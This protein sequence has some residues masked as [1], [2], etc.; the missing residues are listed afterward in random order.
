MPE[1]SGGGARV[2]EPAPDFELSSTLGRPTTRRTERLADGGRWRVL[3]FYPRDF[4]FVCPTELIELSARFEDFRDRECSLL[5]ISADDLETHERWIVTPEKDGG[6]GPLR[7]PLA[8]D[9]D[10]AVAR[11]YGVWVEDKRVA[12]R[13]LFVVD[14]GGVLQYA[15]VHNLGVGRNSAEVLRVIDALRGGGLCPAGWRRGDGTI[16]PGKLLHEGRVLGRYR[17]RGTLGKG[18]FG[19]VLSAWDLWLERDV[20]LKVGAPGGRAD[21]ARVLAEARSAA[22]LNHPNICTVYAVEE[23]EGLPVIAMEHLSGRPLSRVLAGG[24]LPEEEARRIARGIA[25][26]LAASHAA[27]VVHG[28]LKPANVMITDE[29]RVV[30]LDFGIA[31]RHGRIPRPEARLISGGV[32]ISSPDAVGA[33]V[34]TADLLGAT[35][36]TADDR[37]T[38]GGATAPGSAGSGVGLRGTPGYMAPEQLTG[39]LATPESDVFAFGLVLFELLTGHRAIAGATVTELVARL[40]TLEPC[41][42]VEQVPRDWRL[43]LEGALARDPAYRWSLQR[44]VEAI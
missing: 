8:S 26:G 11:S 28:D 15:V 10:G 25:E 24:R 31:V 9:P 43:P 2:G 32:P 7:F 17:I 42:L 38:A 22:A 33:T 1:P 20:A 18:A 6:V 4:T 23:E 21:I 27:G 5:G 39:A 44:I 40:G 34:E 13:G 30:I 16:D 35:A 29:G 36:E 12:N 14:P 37:A 3:V 19:R 41:A